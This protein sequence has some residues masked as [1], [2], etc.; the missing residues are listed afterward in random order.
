M[1]LPWPATTPP[2]LEL[3]G[4]FALSDRQFET[5]YLSQ[6]HALHLHGY[7]GRLRLAATELD[8]QA[9]DVTLSPAGAASAYALPQPGRHW[10]VHFH[11]TEASGLNVELPLHL[12][13]GPA[14]AYAAERLAAINRLHAR[15]GLV[16]QASAAVAFQDLLLWCVA[17]SQEEDAPADALADRVGAIVDTRFAEPL[18]A[19][20]LAREV[21]RSQHYVAQVFRR[22]FGMTVPRYAL[23]RRMAHARYL[24][25]STDLPIAAIAGRVGVHDPHY[26]NKLVRRFL[27]DSP[28]LV[29][30]RARDTLRA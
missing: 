14:A 29:R 12:R 3:A 19:D 16:A 24:L 25:E 28:T 7:A 22:R 20:R 11:P 9:G 30:R 23:Q 10:C 8:L 21:G 5:T 27:G 1:T 2:R 13:L 26:F 4:Q 6:T 17:R 18:T 15:N